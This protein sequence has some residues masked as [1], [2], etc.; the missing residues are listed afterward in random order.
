MVPTEKGDK[1]MKYIYIASLYR[2]GYELTVAE[3]SEGAAR[4]AIVEE[5]ANTFRDING[6]DPDAEESD[7]GH[8]TTWLDDAK[9]DIEIYRMT[10]GKVDWR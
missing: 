6:I 7:R 1:A 2:F 3:K 8:G 5:Y 9:E 10:I 4:A